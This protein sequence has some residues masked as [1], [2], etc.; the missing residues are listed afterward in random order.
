MIDKKNYHAVLPFLGM[1]LFSAA[2]VNGAIVSTTSTDG[3]NPPG[4]AVSGSDLLQTALS[5]SLG[6]ARLDTTGGSG[7]NI[8]SVLNDGNWGTNNNVASSVG[9]GAG[10]Q[11]NF[12]EF[13]LDTTVNVLGY[14][15]TEIVVSAWWSSLRAE[16]YYGMEISYVGNASFVELAP[17]THY[18][19]G[20]AGNTPGATQ[21]SHLNSG[22]GVLDGTNLASGV[23]AIRFNFSGTS[24]L[25]VEHNGLGGN[26]WHFYREIDVIGTPTVIPEPSSLLLLGLGGGFLLRRRRSA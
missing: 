11:A 12:V 24:G 14:D 13:Q 17:L 7:A 21:V 26:D 18:T 3:G 16:Q 23:D 22:G 25:G 15:L 6:F 8:G 2:S 10:P 20:S 1:A 19:P 4:L 5:S 9:F